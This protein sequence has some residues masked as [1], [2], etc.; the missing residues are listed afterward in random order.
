MYALDWLLMFDLSAFPFNSSS[1]CKTSHKICMW[2]IYV[3]CMPLYV[4]WKLQYELRMIRTY[5]N[6]SIA[7]L[8][9]N[10]V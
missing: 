6:R 8:D 2:R 7:G 10:I 4:L 3:Q 9:K 5:L 1:Q